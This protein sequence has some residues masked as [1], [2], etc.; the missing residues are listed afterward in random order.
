M[1]FSDPLWQET[2][3]SMDCIH[4]CNA[5]VVCRAQIPCTISNDEVDFK[6]VTVYITYSYMYRAITEYKNG[7]PDKLM[8]SRRHTNI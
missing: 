5:N 7:K 1:Q 4:I 3:G 8:T 6:V 2:L